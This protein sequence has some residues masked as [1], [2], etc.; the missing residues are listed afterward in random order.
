RCT[1][2]HGDLG[3]VDAVDIGP[4]GDI[5][6][7]TD[8]RIEDSIMWDFPFDKG[9][10]VG[11]GGSSHGIIV[12]NC[13]IYGCFSGVQSKDLC[14]VSVRNSTLVDNNSGFTN[15]NKVNPSSPT[16]GGITTN[17]YNNILW[18][19]TT[20]I[21]MANN[22]QLYADHNDFGNTNWPGEG[23]INADPLFVDAAARNYRLQPAS[24][25]RGTGRDGA[26]RGV[27]YPLGGLPGPALGCAC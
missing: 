18:G 8:A 21:D 14:D 16:G 6:G 24:P 13:L 12:S 17:S 22:G 25:C 19:N 20:T 15:Y 4:S 7:T 26:D 5:P 11:D 10:T 3:N 2:R 9:V 23:N 27:T 1:Y